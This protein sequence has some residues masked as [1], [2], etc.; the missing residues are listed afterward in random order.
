MAGTI[1]QIHARSA[2]LYVQKSA[3]TYS[4]SISLDQAQGSATIFKVKNLT[5]TPPMSE[6][7]AIHLW[8]EDA[9]DSI[10][11]NVVA[12]GTFQHMAMDEKAWTLARAAFT[13]VMSHDE[14]GITAP[15]GNSLEVLFH[16]A[17]ID[18]A[19]TPAFTRYTYGDSTTSARIL[20]GNI[21]FVWNNGSGIKNA[22]MSRVI[23]TKMG[24]MKP[25]GADGHWEQECEAVC[26]PQDFVTEDED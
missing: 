6:V 15:N 19:D 25:T 1:S 11:S 3:I 7:E 24:D 18:V 21:G 12:S 9:L 5:I 20:V 4:A 13:L 2:A 8:G 23:V 26:Y 22:Q 14:A 16:G 10:G 17:G